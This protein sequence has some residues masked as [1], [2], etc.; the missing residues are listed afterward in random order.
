MQYAI[1]Y[2]DDMYII[3]YERL[4]HWQ[5]YGMGTGFVEN[6][7]EAKLST[8]RFIFKQRSAFMEKFPA[9]HSYKIIHA[10]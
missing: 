2:L 5:K 4:Y 9:T 3:E 8:I 1:K 10:I 7:L 6:R